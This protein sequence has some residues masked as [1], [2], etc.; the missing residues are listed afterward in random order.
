M[1]QAQN[2]LAVFQRTL[3]VQPF[4]PLANSE[5]ALAFL[6]MGDTP[7]AMEHLERAVSVW[8]EAE[9]GHKSALAARSKL[10]ELQATR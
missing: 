7:K 6:E 8:R 2:S 1:G 3:A 10:R 9:P 4:Q 5:I